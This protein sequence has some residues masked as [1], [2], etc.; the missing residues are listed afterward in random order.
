MATREWDAHSYDSI[1]APQQE[2][3]AAVLERLMLRGDET[4]LDAGAGTG[5]VSEMVL[6]R[7]P[8]GRLIAV[9]GSHAMAELARARLPRERVTVI[10][11]DLLALE[12]PEPVDAV[13]STAT[14]HWIFDHET[15]FERLRAVLRPGGQFVAQC[16]GRGNIDRVRAI[17][18]EVSAR[19]A[20]AEQLAELPA[21]WHYA[22]AE[23]TRERLERAGFAV[24]ACWIAA[25]PTTPPRPRE[26]LRTVVFAP[27]LE[28]LPSGLH[29]RF[30]DETLA[31]LGDP[32]VLDYQRLNWDAIAV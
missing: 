26:F 2:W 4:V 16:G 20:F 10:H 25:M 29:E 28:H 8:R 12:L 19:P 27:Y 7:I 13:I 3:G 23:E 31:G 32:V 18:A 5:R 30:L 14:F 21:I 17:A 11:S 1:S 24:S 9:D 22:S 15:L 6:E